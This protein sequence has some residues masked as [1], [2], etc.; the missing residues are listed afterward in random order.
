MLF[1][2][3]DRESSMA[4]NRA[5]DP[6]VPPDRKFLLGSPCYSLLQMKSPQQQVIWRLIHLFLRTKNP[7]WS[8]HAI[9]SSRD[10]ILNSNPKRDHRHCQRCSV[11]H[12]HKKRVHLRLIWYNASRNAL[13]FASCWTFHDTQLRRRI[14]V[15]VS[16]VLTHYCFHR[17]IW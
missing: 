14:I 10:G 2:P 7:Q 17:I 5:V 8:H 4:G 6:F 1:A 9:R 3:S 15:V 12:H 11:K 16:V 13:Y